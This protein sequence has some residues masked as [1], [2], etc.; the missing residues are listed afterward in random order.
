MSELN[1]RLFTLQAIGSDIE[2]DLKTAP[3]ALYRWPREVVFRFIPQ[4]EVF[5]SYTNIKTILAAIKLDGWDIAG[6]QGQEGKIEAPGE[7]IALYYRYYD[8]L[9]AQ[10]H[11][12]EAGRFLLY[13]PNPRS[14]MSTEEKIKFNQHFIRQGVPEETIMD[15]WN[16]FSSMMPPKNSVPK[17]PRGRRS[18]LAE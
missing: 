13:H 7:T 18:S 14:L 8:S 3:G 9:P 15:F 6:M 4:G 16:W 1:P 17:K 11:D 10:T 5:G 2:K 12:H